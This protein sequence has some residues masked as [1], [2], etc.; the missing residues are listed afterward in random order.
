MSA[1]LEGGKSTDTDDTLRSAN[2]LLRR[3]RRRQQ[4]MPVISA[5]RATNTHTT[6][7]TFLEVERKRFRLAVWS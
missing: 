1:V 3:A 5:K 7:T 6:A 2:R 4:N